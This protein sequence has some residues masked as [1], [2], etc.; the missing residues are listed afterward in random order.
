M[1]MNEERKALIE[2][3]AKSYPLY[4]RSKLELENNK[5][6]CHKFD[7]LKVKKNL[8]ELDK[9]FLDEFKEKREK[10]YKISLLKNRLRIKLK[11]NIKKL[12]QHIKV[13]QRLFP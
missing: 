8:T 1:N 11:K 7:R 6:N 5:D 4:K 2:M 3:L 12:K 10:L 9:S 13:R